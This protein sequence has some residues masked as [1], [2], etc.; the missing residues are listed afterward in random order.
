MIFVNYKGEI[1]PISFLLAIILI[2]R[3]KMIFSHPG[4][5]RPKSPALV[6]RLLPHMIFFVDRKDR[7]RPGSFLDAVRR[8]GLRGP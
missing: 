7:I 1:R 8:K 3:K 6:S 2:A 4:R 5:I